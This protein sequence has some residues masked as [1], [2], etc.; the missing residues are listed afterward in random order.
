MG[1]LGTRR[2]RKNVLV[3]EVR[4]AEDGTSLRNGEKMMILTNTTTRES[5]FPSLPI[6]KRRRKRK[7]RR[8]NRDETRTTRVGRSLRRALR[9]LPMRRRNHLTVTG[10]RRRRRK[11]LLTPRKRRKKIRRTT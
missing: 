3:L 2:K 4:P 8:R 9:L 10:R 11:N 1:G 7:R 6:P 5:S